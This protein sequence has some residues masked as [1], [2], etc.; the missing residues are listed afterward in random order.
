ML[1]LGHHQQWL[2][3]TGRVSSGCLSTYTSSLCTQVRTAVI[4]I[5]TT[6]LLYLVVVLSVRNPTVSLDVSAWLAKPQRRHRAWMRTNGFQRGR[7]TS[8]TGTIHMIHNEI[9]LLSFIISCRE[10]TRLFRLSK[11]NQLCHTPSVI[12]VAFITQW[13]WKIIVF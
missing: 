9:S 8:D 11:E 13:D 6:R 2:D 3:C 5:P 4:A 7:T 12:L 1:A 10:R